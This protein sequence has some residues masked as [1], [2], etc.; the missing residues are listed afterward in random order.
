MELKEFIKTA[1]TD[2]TDAVSELQEELKNGAIV[3]PSMPQAISNV[4]VIDPQNDNINR[5]ISKIDF[6]VAI[7]VGSKDNVEAGGKV[8]IQIFSAKIGG[9]IEKHTENVSRITFSIPVVLPT[10]HV[11]TRA[12]RSDERTISSQ[13]KLR[14]MKEQNLS[15]D[16]PPQTVP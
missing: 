9:D 3:S 7:T 12:E 11:K 13:A 5:P 8:G 1:L 4:T 6:D 14:K 10:C 2:I 15:A 16:N